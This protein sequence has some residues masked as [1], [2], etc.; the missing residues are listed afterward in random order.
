[1][2]GLKRIVNSLQ[3]FVKWPGFV[4]RISQLTTGG[5]TKTEGEEKIIKRLQES[6][7]NSSVDAHDVSGGC[8][9]MYEVYIES[10]QFRG[11]R[12]VAQHQMVNKALEKEIKE[13]HGLRITTEV[14]KVEAEKSKE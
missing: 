11:K 8:G 13:M 12:I 3:T 6:F 9:A 14:P 10:E 2:S 5:S 4:Q 1:M 7:P